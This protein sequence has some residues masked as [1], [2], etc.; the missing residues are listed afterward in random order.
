MFSIEKSNGFCDLHTHSL[1]SDGTLTP[2][3][4]IKLAEKM[5]ILA[6]A[7]CDHNTTAGLAEF[8]AAGE[9]SSTIA[10]AGIEISTEY[11]GKELHII[12]LFVDA[13]RIRELDEFVSQI[14][15]N[16]EQANIKLANRLCDAGYIVDYAKI[17]KDAGS[18][19]P[20]RVYFANELIKGGYISTI[21][22]GF[23]TLLSE[24]NGF[25]IPPQRIDA[26]DAIE[27]LSSIGALP[28]LAHPLLNLTEQELRVFLP[29]ASAKG[30]VAIE[31]IY[32]LF[33]DGETCLLEQLAD[34]LG[35]LKSGGSDFHGENKP[36]IELGMG[37]GDL[38]VPFEYFTA[39]Q[40]A[41]N[42]LKNKN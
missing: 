33:S 27:F 39:L 17:K 5:N 41:K 31:T 6:V 4:I 9:N 7:L 3:K 42:S 34:E 19:T 25:Y 10:V 40:N 30:L 14:N 28:I 38:R 16:K 11:I 22:E 24:K 21:K 12:G 26:F 1:F 18:I 8:L 13:C 29:K 35:L 23:K 15:K 32:S 20:N 2:R 37:K 36:D